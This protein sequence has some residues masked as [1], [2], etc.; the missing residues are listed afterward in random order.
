MQ[1]Q[2][3]NHTMQLVNH[4]CQCSQY[5]CQSSHADAPTAQGR[6]H[7][8]ACPVWTL[9]YSDSTARVFTARKWRRRRAP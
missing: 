7:D 5:G 4:G 2:L 3:V 6:A 8:V 1:M 9:E